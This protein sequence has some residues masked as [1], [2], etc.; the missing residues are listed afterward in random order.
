MPK[1]IQAD[2][3]IN[4]LLKQL[5]LTKDIQEIYF[6]WEKVVGENLASKV[7]LVGIKKDTLIIKVSSSAYY[8]Q[9]KLYQKEWLK[10]INIFLGENL[11]RHLKV[12]K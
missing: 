6:Y 11:I 7:Q 4:K 3:V 5:G 9:L 8:H 2:V 10:K 12:I 1:F